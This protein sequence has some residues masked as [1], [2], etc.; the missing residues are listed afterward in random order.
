MSPTGASE[1]AV[2]EELIDTVSEAQLT[3]IHGDA[4]R[5]GN[6][7]DLIFTSNPTLAKFSVSIP[8]IS[9]HEAVIADFDTHPIRVKEKPKRYFLFSKAKWDEITEDLK[10]LA[11][12]ME[13][14]KRKKE[15]IDVMWNHFKKTIMTT[16][17][18]HVPSRLRRNS[19]DLPWMNRKLKRLIRLKKRL[20]QRA[21]KT[22]NWT[23]YR[24]VQ[25]QCRREFRKAEQMYINNTI[26]AGFQQNDTKPFWRYVK[27]RRQ[28][29]VGVAPLK[30]GP[31]LFSDTVTK[32][33]ILLKQFCSVFTKDDGSG[34]PKMD[35]PPHPCIEELKV[36]VPGVAKLLRNLNASKATGP[37][38]IPS[39]ILKHCADTLAPPLTTIFNYSLE[40]GSLPSDW[41]TANIA[42]VFKKGDRNKAENYRPVSLTSVSCKLLEHVICHHLRNHLEKH[43][44]LTD[45]NHGFRSG[46]S[47]ETQLLTTMHD[48]LKSNDAKTQTDVIILDFS[49]AFDTVPH[50]KLLSKLQHYGIKGPV[51]HWITTFL[52]KRTMRVLLEGEISKEA[53]VESGVPQGTV[54]GPLL[55]LCHINDLPQTV[56]S[57]VRLFA[58]DCLLYREIR[59]FQDHLRLQADLSK[60]EVWA[61]NW[62]MRFNASKCY[63]LP[64]KDTSKYFYRLNGEILKH[65]EHNPYLGIQISADLKWG[66]HI[67]MMCKKARSTLGFLRRNLGTCPP[68][69]RHMAYISLLRSKLEY[70]AVV[71]DPYLQQDIDRIERI[72]KQAARFITRDYRTREAGCVTRMLQNWNL[73]PLQERRRQQRLVTLYKITNREIPA[74]PPERFLTEN[75]HGKSRRQIRPKIF[76]DCVTSNPIARHA[77]RH[78][79]GYKVPDSTTEQ[80]ASSF[81]VRTVVEWNQLTED[82]VQATSATAFS[83][84]V[85]KPLAAGRNP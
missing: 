81:F 58:D 65:V 48:L 85:G 2:Q 3:Q 56:T 33:S 22:K 51:H 13:S 55:F 59:N 79:K 53:C 69:C 82:T 73:R 41:L 19:N 16:V 30:D 46:H 23:K 52:T 78:T 8:G 1:K 50:A 27:S 70:G 72:Q 84:A 83:A 54:L 9:D 40:T 76:A 26:E 57:S 6:M 31:T 32:A 37:D 25:K 18:N 38:G 14:M 5:Q 62:G 49:K 60:L 39:N 36:E 10:P 71:W 45:K 67:N 80:Y 24:F 64:T 34:I 77:V 17:E 7:L 29:N 35:G 28:D 66:T 63:V 74:L 61:Q 15:S 43:G 4:T 21:K 68:K 11:E 12:L 47:C 44:I 42:S 20:H 75:D